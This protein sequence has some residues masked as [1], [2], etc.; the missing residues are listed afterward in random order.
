MLYR[1]FDDR[2]YMYIYLPVHQEF[3]YQE[4]YY[5]GKQKNQFVFFRM[6]LWTLV[7][8]TF[9]PCKQRKMFTQSQ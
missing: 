1:L 7:T 9:K 5:L 8:F 4:F 2:K 6:N 3:Y